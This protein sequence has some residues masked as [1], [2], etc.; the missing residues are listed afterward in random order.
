MNIVVF[1]GSA[2]GNDPDFILA[3]R[4]LGSW[5]GENG[6]DLVWGG[7]RTGLMGAVADAAR[8]AGAKLTG[9]LTNNPTIQARKYPYLD[10][11]V[12]TPDLTA[13]KQRMFQLGDAFVALPGGPGTW[14]EIS[15]VISLAKLS[16]TDYPIVFINVNGFYDSTRQSLQDMA[17]A[18]FCSA[19]L[20]E[21]IQFIPFSGS[22]ASG[23]DA[24]ATPLTLAL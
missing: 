17:D 3:A 20:L 19:Q 11:C 23:A 7:C 4:Q 8:A 13:R 15:D 10:V 16:P 2:P 24:N 12:E 21:R 9:V 14:D 22:D 5:I 1:C 6:H 18:G